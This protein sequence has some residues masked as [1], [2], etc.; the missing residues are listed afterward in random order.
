MIATGDARA[1]EKTNKDLGRY[2]KNSALDILSAAPSRDGRGG[3]VDMNFSKNNDNII[4]EI[5]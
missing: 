1:K 3:G 5:I 2:L 4:C